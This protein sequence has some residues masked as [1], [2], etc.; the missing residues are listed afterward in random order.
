MSIFELCWHVLLSPDHR[1]V[2]TV[3]RL[4]FPYG[5]LLFVNSDDVYQV[6]HLRL[7]SALLDH[8]YSLWLSL[9]G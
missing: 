5:H 6:I 2:H 3:P 9:T 8:Y 1:T 7:G 4:S